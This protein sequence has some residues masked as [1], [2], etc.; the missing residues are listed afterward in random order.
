MFESALERVRRVHRLY[1]YGYVVMREHVRLLLSEPQR[2]SDHYVYAVLHHPV[3]RERY[4]ANLRRELPRIPFVSA[5]ALNN[6]HSEEH[7]DEESAVPLPGKKQIPPSARNNN[8]P[9]DSVSSVPSVV[10]DV[11]V[12]RPPRL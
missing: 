8:S 11:D 9:R 1:V 4:A 7:G 10:K 2:E 5:P 6:C 3:Y 12:F